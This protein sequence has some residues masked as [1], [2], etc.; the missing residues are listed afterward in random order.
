MSLDLIGLDNISIIEGYEEKKDNNTYHILVIMHNQYHPVC[1]NCGSKAF[2]KHDTRTRDFRDLS[3]F[4]RHIIL[5]ANYSSYKCLTCNRYFNEDYSDIVDNGA[6]M[7]KRMRSEVGKRC[8]DYPFNAVARD[9]AISEA[10]CRRAFA[11]WIEDKDIEKDKITYA[12]RVMGIDEA[13]LANG[14]R[15]VITD[16]ENNTLIEM[17]ESRKVDHLLPFLQNLHEPKSLEVVTIDMWSGYREAIYEVFGNDINIVIDRFHVIKH[18]NDAARKCKN[19]LQKQ[20]GLPKGSFK[21]LKRPQHLFMSNLEDLSE[22]DKEH[23]AELFAVIP[24]I[25][26]AYTIKESFRNIYNTCSSI[27]EAKKAYIKWCASVPKEEAYKPFHTFMKTVDKWEREI[28]NY[29]KHPYTNAFT[30]AFNGLT[31]KVNRLGNGYSFPVLRAKMLYTDGLQKVKKEKRTIK[32][33]VNINSGTSMSKF[34]SFDLFM[35][36]SQSRYGEKMNDVEEKKVFGADL[37]KV[38]ELLNQTF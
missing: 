36:E 26:V 28:F 16:N 30:E 8:L 25:K 19:N 2:Q 38:I 29:F 3:A 6:R 18:L 13:H 12:P 4:G 31:K 20:A 5:R 11:D 14:M 35:R 7:T 21:Q 15:G 10:T 22:D 24:D 34:I 37:E 27:K 23:L 1:P 17:L 9:Y 32:Q 33:K